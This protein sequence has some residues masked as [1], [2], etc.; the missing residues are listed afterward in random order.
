MHPLELTTDVRELDQ[1]RVQA[2]LTDLVADE[3]DAAEEGAR[4]GWMR[5]EV[6]REDAVDQ[7]DRQRSDR[8]EARDALAGRAC[9]VAGAAPP[10]GDRVCIGCLVVDVGRT[11]LDREHRRV[12]GVVVGAEPVVIVRLDRRRFGFGVGGEH[13]PAS[14]AAVGRIATEP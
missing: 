9:G 13:V 1:T 5:V 8:G 14:G 12:V 10:R 7:R 3:R 4:L 2:R 11:R 6:D